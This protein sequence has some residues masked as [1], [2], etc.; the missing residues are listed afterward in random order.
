MIRNEIE[1]PG[2]EGKPIFLDQ[3]IS[4]NGGSKG[5]VVFCHGFKGFKDWGP[6]NKIAETFAENDFV[7]IKFNF[8]HNGTT[9]DDAVNFVD[10]EAFGNN[11]FC[12]E[13]E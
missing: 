3:T 1:L 11:N 8:S 13:L 4:G 2:Q 5:V 7:F 9:L 12:K 6:F 10:L